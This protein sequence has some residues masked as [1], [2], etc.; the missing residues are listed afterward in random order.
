MTDKA[1]DD[2]TE[3]RA[4]LQELLDHSGWANMTDGDLEEEAREGNGK[5]PIILRCRA[6][7]KAKPA[8]ASAETGGVKS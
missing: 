6:A 5:A 1:Q 4:A 7:I 2:T 3:L 8:R